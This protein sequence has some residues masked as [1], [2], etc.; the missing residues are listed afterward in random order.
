MWE[1]NSYLVEKNQKSNDEG[2]EKKRCF[3]KK[4]YDGVLETSNRQAEI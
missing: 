4:A 3:C 1:C 2:G